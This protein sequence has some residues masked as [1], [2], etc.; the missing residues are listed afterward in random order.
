MNNLDEQNLPFNKSISF[1]TLSFE[2]SD[3]QF[4]RL[5]IR[6]GRRFTMID[7]DQNS[8]KTLGSKLINWA[9]EQTTE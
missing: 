2:N 9:N 7:L 3:M 1:K 6:E 4:L 5:T 8:A